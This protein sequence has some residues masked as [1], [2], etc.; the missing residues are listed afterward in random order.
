MTKIANYDR[1]ILD[2]SPCHVAS[3]LFNL[4]DD[5]LEHYLTDAEYNNYYL[6]DFNDSEQL[7]FWLKKLVR[8]IQSTDKDYELIKRSLRQIISNKSAIPIDI[9]LPGI[10]SIEDN[11]QW[12]KNYEIFLHRLWRYLFDCNFVWQP[13]INYRE[14]IDAEFINFPHVPEMWK[15]A[16]YAENC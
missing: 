7:N 16:R 3:L 5:S 4:T 8:K 2:F 10:E 14:R 15:E 12:S 9:Y 6:A 11:N 13:T 1:E